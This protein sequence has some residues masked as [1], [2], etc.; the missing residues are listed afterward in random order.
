[1]FFIAWDVLYGTVEHHVGYPTVVAN[2][3]DPISQKDGEM[4]TQIVSF[5][6][7]KTTEN[8]AADF[9]TII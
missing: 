9:D 3:M 6:L 7:R 2:S 8:G 4:G 1:M 5:T